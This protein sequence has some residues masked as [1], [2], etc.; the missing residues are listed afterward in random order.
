ME[1]MFEGT[2]VM[3][4]AGYPAQMMI[5]CY[6]R[7]RKLWKKLIGGYDRHRTL[8]REISGSCMTCKK[9]V[10]CSNLHLLTERVPAT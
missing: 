1:A 6:Y 8:W 10:K 4:F 5:G 3:I 9:Y 2:P 7:R